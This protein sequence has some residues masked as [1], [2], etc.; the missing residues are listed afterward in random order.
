MKEIKSKVYDHFGSWPVL[1]Q[2]QGNTGFVFKKYHSY[3][4]YF[5]GGW[6]ENVK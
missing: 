6:N 2:R 3:P 5:C 1:Q 4:I